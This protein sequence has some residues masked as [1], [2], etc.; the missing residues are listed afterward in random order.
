MIPCSSI[1]D[2][3]D[4]FFQFNSPGD[5]SHYGLCGQQNLRA[6]I[7]EGSDSVSS[8]ERHIVANLCMDLSEINDISEDSRGFEDNILGYVE[9]SEILNPSDPTKE[10]ESSSA[11]F[12]IA[13][14]CLECPSVQTTLK[15]KVSSKEAT[16]LDRQLRPPKKD[17]RG[18]HWMEKA[19]QGKLLP[20]PS[21]GKTD[22]A[23]AVCTHVH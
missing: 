18:N 15:R 1:S 19:Q 23:K 5:D 4:K 2:L 3:A 9:G 6:G 10:S 14:D 8:M 16:S 12:I 17:R 11:T 22:W 21:T 20:T 7:N 13:G